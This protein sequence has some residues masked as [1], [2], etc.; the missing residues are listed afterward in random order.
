MA[1]RKIKGRVTVRAGIS[2][3]IA[4][5]LIT[6]A[7]LAP[8]M[9]T[10]VRGYAQV[11]GATLSGVVRDASGAAIPN[12]TVSLKNSATDATRIATTDVAGFYSM[13]N[14]LPGDYSVTA[15]ATGFSTL[16]ET[17]ITLEV[18]AARLLDL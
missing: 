8:V 2:D 6:F 15:S 9:L 5:F 10:S 3:S 12:V 18:G 7:S 1:D 14:M 11:A 17:S 13:P 16:V 4:V